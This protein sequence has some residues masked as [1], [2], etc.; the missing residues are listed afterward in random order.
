LAKTTSHGSAAAQVAISL[1][2]KAMPGWS[3]RAASS[4]FADES[5]PVTDASGQRCF[6][7]PVLLPRPQPR[8]TTERGASSSIRDNRSIA[9]K[10]RASAKRK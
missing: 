3:R 7:K 2:T 5:S 1:P 4:R 9:G 8:S 6:S 10:V